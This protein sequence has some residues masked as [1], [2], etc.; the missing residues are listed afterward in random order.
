MQDDKELIEYNS[1][2]LDALI[3]IAKGNVDFVGQLKELQEQLK[4]LIATADPKIV[5][6][7]KTIKNEIGDLRI[8]L[9]KSD[10]EVSFGVEKLSLMFDWLPRTEKRGC[11]D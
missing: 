4:Y 2:S 6:L 5:D 3:V 9:T 11:E 7:D 1:K 8:A 10:G